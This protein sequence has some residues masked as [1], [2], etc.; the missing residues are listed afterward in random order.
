MVGCLRICWGHLS[1]QSAGRTR[2]QEDKE[3]TA[4]RTVTKI[5]IMMVRVMIEKEE[6]SEN[7]VLAMMDISDT[8]L[9]NNNFKKRCRCINLIRKVNPI[10]K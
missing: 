5:K 8:A 7:T 1:C 6:K 2:R 3:A 4:R 9:V 10:C